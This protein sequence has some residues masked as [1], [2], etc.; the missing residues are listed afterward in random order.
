MRNMLSHLHLYFAITRPVWQHGGVG[1]LI[2]ASQLQGPPSP[3]VALC[4][5][6]AIHVTLDVQLVA[7]FH[8]TLLIWTRGL[9]F[10]CMGSTSRHCYA[11]LVT[12]QYGGKEMG[13]WLFR[14]QETERNMGQVHSLPSSL[15]FPLAGDPAPSIVLLVLQYYVAFASS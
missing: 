8:E 10:P 3:A 1:P 15:N 4:G 9:E 12:S 14:C 2:C 7:V 6:C 13:V 5:A 11:N